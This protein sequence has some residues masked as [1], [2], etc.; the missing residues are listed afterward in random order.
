MINKWMGED[1]KYISFQQETFT[2]NNKGY[3]VL[4][5]TH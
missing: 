2:L 1:I 3:P 5:N 4:A